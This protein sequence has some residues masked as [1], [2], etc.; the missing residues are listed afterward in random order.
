MSLPARIKISDQANT[1]ANWIDQWMTPYKGS[2][3]VMANLRHLYEAVFGM[4]VN[5]APK[6][7]ICYNGETARGGFDERNTLD[8][9]DREWV[10]VLLRGH[11][12]RNAMSRQEPGQEIAFYDAVEQLREII[13]R[14]TSI[15]EE[16][17]IDFKSIR[18]LPG[19]AQPNAANVFL[20]GYAIEFTTANDI[21]KITKV[22]P[23][24]EAE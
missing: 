1:L 7:L 22:A 17:P 20:D 18:P 2:V 23:G 6:A 5:N 24:Q 4:G 12:F 13:R 10:V 14:V 15:S 11:G 9:V 3:E 19:V 8:R 21:P 16:F